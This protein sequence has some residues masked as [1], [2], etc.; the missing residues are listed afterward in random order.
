MT[1]QEKADKIRELEFVINK[2]VSFQHVI[3][4]PLQIPKKQP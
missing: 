3:F 2:I 4:N 1:A